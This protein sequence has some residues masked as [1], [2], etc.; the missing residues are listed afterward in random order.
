VLGDV[1][2]PNSVL[3]P[4]QAEAQ[5]V[6]RDRYAAGTPL[7]AY[8]V[9]PDNLPVIDEYARQ[10]AEQVVLHLPTLPA[11]DALTVLDAMVKT[12]QQYR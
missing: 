9:A 12:A 3:D 6:L 4:A 1:W 5:F 11:D 2:M 7:M 8:A 10:G